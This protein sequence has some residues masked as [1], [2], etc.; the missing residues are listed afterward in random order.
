MKK[1]QKKYDKIKKDTSHA[2]L[3]RILIVLA[4]G[5]G[6]SVPKVSTHF[7]ICLVI[8]GGEFICGVLGRGRI[9]DFEMSLRYSLRYVLR[10]WVYF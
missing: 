2:L 3:L 6:D 7:F 10:V 8:W 5:M 4:L 9:V 1:L